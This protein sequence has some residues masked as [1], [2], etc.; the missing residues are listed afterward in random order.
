MVYSKHV[1]KLSVAIAIVLSVL[2]LG[3]PLTLKPA[4]GA[5]FNGAGT[6]V[7]ILSRDRLAMIAFF[8]D[9]AV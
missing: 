4:I 3:K 2:F 7:R 1:P 6:L 9:Q 5:G 8:T